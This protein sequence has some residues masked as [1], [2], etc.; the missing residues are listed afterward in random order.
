LIQKIKADVAAILPVKGRP[1]LLKEA[2]ESIMEGT[3]LP[4]SIFVVIDSTGKERQIDQRAAETSF[5]TFEKIYPEV[6]YRLLFSENAGPA[7]ARN[8]AAKEADEEWITFLDSDDLWLPEKLELQ[9]SYLKKRPHLHGVS[10]LERWIK[11]GKILNQPQKLRPGHGRFLKDSLY[12]CLVPCSSVMLRK[13]IFLLEGGFDESFPVCE[14]YEFWIRFLSKYP[15]GLIHREIAVKRSGTW[16]QLSQEHSLD[17]FRIRALLK[18]GE[19]G[20]LSEEYADEAKKACYE[21]F[22]ILESGARKR[23]NTGDI[24]ELLLSIR[25]IFS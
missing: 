1:D 11:N 21:K 9:F 24:E 5:Q 14:D 18:A 20:V 25:K 6:K 15:L 4:S 8:T 12:R 13:K 2:L 19:S 3:V 10:G 23:G 7:G 22:S 17:R 16:K